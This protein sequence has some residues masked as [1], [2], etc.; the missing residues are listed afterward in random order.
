M[1]FLSYVVNPKLANG[2]LQLTVQ[3][4]LLGRKDM[5]QRATPCM[6]GMHHP[7]YTAYDRPHPLEFLSPMC[8][9][10]FLI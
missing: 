9:G 5:A 6:L 4:G 10:S 8:A 1:S 7:P 2:K 3:D